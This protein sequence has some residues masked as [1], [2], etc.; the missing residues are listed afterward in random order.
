MEPDAGEAP[1]ARTDR[2]QESACFPTDAES[3]TAS[4]AT[5]AFAD[6]GMQVHAASASVPSLDAKRALS[7]AAGEAADALDASMVGLG[8]DIVE[9]ARMEQVLARSPSFARR[10]FSEAECAYCDATALR[11]AHYAARFAA[12]EAVLKAL[13]TGFSCGVGVRDV[14]VARGK[15]G[16]PMAVLSGRAAAIAQAD[17]VREIALSLSYTHNEAVACALAV[18]EASVQAR[19]ERIDPKEELA[20]AFKETRGLLDDI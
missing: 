4:G 3:P 11:A 16:R 7:A 8:V 2:P 12:K 13:G 19:E 1:G 18:T 10:V 20:R 9:V 6:D 5:A 17:G 14:E 15:N